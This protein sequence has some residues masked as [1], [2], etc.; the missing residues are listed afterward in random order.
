M[1]FFL[2]KPW[3][4]LPVKHGKAISWWLGPVE[5]VDHTNPNW[6]RKDS[7]AEVDSEVALMNSASIFRWWFGH[8]FLIYWTFTQVIFIYVIYFTSTIVPFYHR[9]N[10]MV[11]LPWP[12]SFHEDE[13]AAVGDLNGV[14][15]ISVVLKKY[16]RFDSGLGGCGW[17]ISWEEGPEEGRSVWKGKLSFTLVVRPPWWNEWNSTQAGVKAEERWPL[18]DPTLIPWWKMKWHCDT[19]GVNPWKPVASHTVFIFLEEGLLCD[20]VPWVYITQWL[21]GLGLL[22]AG[23]EF[24]CDTPALHH[25]WNMIYSLYKSS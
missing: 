11:G 23:L 21:S 14:W 24:D 18:W 12:W 5:E 3:Q 20:Q 1:R 4:M 13:A 7:H 19:H 22:P 25:W 15:A 6:I 8:H 17:D 9:R 2:G 10:F 16:A